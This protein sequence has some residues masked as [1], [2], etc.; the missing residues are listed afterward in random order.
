MEAIPVTFIKFN[1]KRNE[2]TS[3]IIR[4]TLFPNKSTS[5]LKY[6]EEIEEDGNIVQRSRS[7]SYDI[8]SFVVKVGQLIKNKYDECYEYILYV[9]TAE[10]KLKTYLCEDIFDVLLS[11]IDTNCL[12]IILWNTYLNRFLVFEDYKKF[13]EA[14][15]YDM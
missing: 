3:C 7:T 2:A 11:K 9:L 8:D 10:S 15:L 1:R 14:D 6:E 5:P 13:K 4:S 12:Y